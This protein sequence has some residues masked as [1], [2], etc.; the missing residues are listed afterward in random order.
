MCEFSTQNKGSDNTSN[1]NVRK[2]PHIV[3][4]RVSL[5]RGQVTTF[6]ERFWS[7]VDRRGDDECWPWIGGFGTRGYGQINVDGKN[8]G[9]HRIAYLLTTGES[10]AGFVI[11]HRCDNPPCCNPG[12]LHRGSQQDNVADAVRRRR[13]AHG[14]TCG[15]AKLTA[16]QARAL[17]VAPSR[18]DALALCASF[19]VSAATADDIRAG[20]S[21]KS[22]DRRAA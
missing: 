19:G 7:K 20:R 3:A 1:D 2:Y 9:A 15:R 22:L 10:I 8:V 5:W 18:A 13:H 6:G 12:H 11:R 21:W 4:G 17:L 14:E 16:V